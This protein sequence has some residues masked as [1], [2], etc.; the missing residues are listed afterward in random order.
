MA[1]S[2]LSALVRKIVKND[3][4]LRYNIIYLVVGVTTPVTAAGSN[5]AARFPGVTFQESDT[6]GGTS[7][8][9]G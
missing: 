5:I 8:G 9:S 2:E 7:G 6:F 4:Q 3:S 1:Y